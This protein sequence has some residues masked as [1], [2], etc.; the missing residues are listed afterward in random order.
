MVQ[1]IG[2]KAKNA[3]INSLT[4][5]GDIYIMSDME[6]KCIPKHDKVCNL[7]K[8]GKYKH[9][10]CGNEYSPKERNKIY[11][12]KKI[13]CSICSQKISETSK[14]KMCISCYHKNIVNP[15]LGKKLSNE[16]KQNISLGQRNEKGNNWGGDKA[17]YFSIHKNLIKNNGNP[18]KC[19]ICN[20]IG[21]R[22]KRSWNL[23]WASKDGKY[24]RNI[25]DYIGLCTSCHYKQEK[26]LQYKLFYKGK[27]LLQNIVGV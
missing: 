23:Q 6:L 7:H 24:T 2:K 25:K 1:A 12:L 27:R 4:I 8:T 16:W 18:I 13:K 21:E 15:R 20:K 9:W 10:K 22:K 14:S 26:T 17:G 11:L 19:E 3:G 5:V